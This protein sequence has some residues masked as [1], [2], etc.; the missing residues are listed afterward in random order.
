[1]DN[2]KRYEL[3]VLRHAKSAWEA[4]SLQD[5][6]RPLSD[7]GWLN[8]PLIGRWMRDCGLIPELILSSPAL[9]AK[10]TALAVAAELSFDEQTIDFKEHLYLADLSILL[11][12]VRACDSAKTRILLV[13]HNPGLDALVEYLC[14]S[15]PPRTNH[16][17]LMTTAA[18]AHI[19]LPMQW[20]NIAQASGELKNLI[21][22][23]ELG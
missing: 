12:T 7:R 19:A 1:M 9:R 17:K 4:P 6:D 11:N 2:K 15:K 5:Y 8:A 22:P 14:K 18:L 13:G 10:Q 23:K 16:G 3:L 20:K 21:R